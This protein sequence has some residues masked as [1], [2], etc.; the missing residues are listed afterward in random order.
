[1][2]QA[3]LRNELLQDDEDTVDYLMSRDAREV[4]ELVA[5]LDR[6]IKSVCRGRVEVPSARKQR[7]LLALILLRKRLHEIN[8]K[9]RSRNLEWVDKLIREACDN[10]WASDQAL[11]YAMVASKRIPAMYNTALKAALIDERIDGSRVSFLSMTAKD[12]R[13]LLLDSP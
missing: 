5:F 11:Y 12:F 6:F 1:M 10:F 4:E 13:S 2:Q 3:E 8:D 9:D 7:A